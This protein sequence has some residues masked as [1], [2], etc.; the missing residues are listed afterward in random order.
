M[1]YFHTYNVRRL[2][3]GVNA[4]SVGCLLPY[5]CSLYC[6]VCTS[7]LFSVFSEIWSDKV[8]LLHINV[9]QRGRTRRGKQ[10]ISRRCRRHKERQRRSLRVAD[11]FGNK[12][13]KKSCKPLFCNEVDKNINKTRKYPLF[14]HAPTVPLCLTIAAI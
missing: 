8:S 2:G 14:L 1:E 6:T 5:C 7:A 9:T 4:C 3:G 11:N 10:T 12:H 13:F